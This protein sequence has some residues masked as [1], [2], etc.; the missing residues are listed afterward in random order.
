MLMLMLLLLSLLALPSFHGGGSVTVLVSGE[1]PITAVLVFALSKVLLWRFCAD[2]G[3]CMRM[4][5]KHWLHCPLR[6]CSSLCVQTLVA[7]PDVRPL[8]RQRFNVQGLIDK[9]GHDAM[10]A[11]RLGTL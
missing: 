3:P 2:V 1:P 6:P 9:A 7:V 8:L 5:P 11:G 10:R 4:T